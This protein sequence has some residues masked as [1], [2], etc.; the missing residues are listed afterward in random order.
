MLKAEIIVTGAE[1]MSHIKVETDSHN[2]NDWVK[3][4]IKGE[5]VEVQ[6][7]EILEAIKMAS[8]GYNA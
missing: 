2:I 8:G 7:S 4:T 1:S 3:L 6:A 5:S